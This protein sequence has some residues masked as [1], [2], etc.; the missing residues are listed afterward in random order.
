MSSKIL[1]ET[2]LMTMQFGGL[3][4]VDSVSISVP[5]GCL[6]GLIG[7][8]GAGKTTAF[9]MLTGVYQPS[10]GEVLFNGKSVRGLKPNQISKLG[11][12]RTF[13]N[14]RLFKGLTVMDNSTIPAFQHTHTGLSDVFFQ[15]KKFLAEEKSVREA[16]MHVLEI[17]GLDKYAYNEA[18]SLPYGSQR[19]L[20]IVRA[21]MSRPKMILLDEPAAGMNHAETELL[22]K[23]IEKIRKEFNVTVLLIEHDMKL[24][25][26]ICE[27]I[28]V[29]DHG[30]KIADGSPQEIRNSPKVIEA[31]LG[32]DED[33]H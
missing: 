17:F 14:I 16:A 15:T 3:K 13:Q 8:N 7:P 20:E 2:Q 18:S 10:S 26:G 33:L 25:M 30:I 31:Y 23:L 22:M 11:L 21:L 28:F 9:N 4:A 5:E 24:V 6:Y 32:V 12:A 19:K 29:L 27:R 1:L